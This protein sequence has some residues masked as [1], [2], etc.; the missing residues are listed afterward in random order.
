MTDPVKFI[1]AKSVEEWQYE[2][3]INGHNFSTY[4][5]ESIVKDLW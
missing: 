4:Y 5:G 1:I 2:N 3:Y